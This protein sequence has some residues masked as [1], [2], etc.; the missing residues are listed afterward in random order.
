MS[1]IE[2]DFWA[3]IAQIKAKSIDWIFLDEGAYL[4][5]DSETSA[6]D[7]DGLPKPEMQGSSVF[8]HDS[9]MSK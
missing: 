5:I 7:V 3:E 2:A 6:I 9:W 8:W 1:S 4:Q